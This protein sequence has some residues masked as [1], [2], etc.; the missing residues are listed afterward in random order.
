[1]LFYL[2]LPLAF[3]HNIKLLFS[4]L[5][6]YMA[7]VTEP[8]AESIVELLPDDLPWRRIYTGIDIVI[9][10]TSVCVQIALSTLRLADPSI[11][12]SINLSILVIGIFNC[13]LFALKTAVR[14]R[15]TGLHISLP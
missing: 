11:I 1:M 6:F 13:V 2:V 7:S 9:F 4:L 15:I 10:F 12:P 8:V 5:F 14:R 3:L